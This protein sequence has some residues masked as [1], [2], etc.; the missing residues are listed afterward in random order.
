[1]L[2]IHATITGAVFASALTL[3]AGVAVAADAPKVGV[4][5]DD[6]DLA[7]LDLL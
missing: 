1:M 5:S 3:A 7:V 4:R 6:P 2:K